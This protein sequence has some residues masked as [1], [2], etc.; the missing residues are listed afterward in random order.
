[1]IE[2]RESKPCNSRDFIGTPITGK[3]V[4]DAVIP[5]KC[6]APPAPAIITS[7]PLIFLFVMIYFI[8]S[9]ALRENIEEYKNCLSQ[10]KDIENVK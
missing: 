3:D 9:L 10:I 7:I 6:A 8:S 4:K 5:G 1:M 2:R